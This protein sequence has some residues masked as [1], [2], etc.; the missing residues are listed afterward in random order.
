MIKRFVYLQNNIVFFNSFH[1]FTIIVQFY[2]E[3]I[4]CVIICVILLL[5]NNLIP[6]FDR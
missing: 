5:Y 6:S 3:L 4:F 1:Q 2:N